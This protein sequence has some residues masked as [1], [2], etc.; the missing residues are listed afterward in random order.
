MQHFNIYNHIQNLNSIFVLNYNNSQLHIKHHKVCILIYRI[1]LTHMH[2]TLSTINPF[3]RKNLIFYYYQMETTAYEGESESN[4]LA[5]SSK[6]YMLLMHVSPSLQKLTNNLIGGAS[7]PNITKDLNQ[8]S[9]VNDPSLTNSNIF[10]NNRVVRKSTS[11]FG[12]KKSQ[13]R[14]IFIQNSDSSK[15]TAGN[16]ID[17]VISSSH[18]NGTVDADDLE[19][20]KILDIKENELKNLN[21]KYMDMKKEISS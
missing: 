19:M 12:Q 10:A 4:M 11:A 8:T 20:Q 3:F 14:L 5:E 2:T 9:K 17:S 16:G 7:T 15:M 6:N 21:K 1:K 13:Q 18:I